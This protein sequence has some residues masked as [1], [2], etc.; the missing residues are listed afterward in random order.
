MKK[1]L[2]QIALKYQIRFQLLF[3]LILGMASF[4]N[5]QGTVSYLQSAE[6]RAMGS[7]QA[8]AYGISSLFGN[9]AGLAKLESFGAIATAE[10]RFAGSGI[11]FGGAGAAIPSELG[12]FGVKV[13]YF[14]IPAYNEQAIGI[15]YSRLLFESFSLSVQANL[16]NTSIEEYGSQFNI[17]GTLG[18]QTYLNKSITVGM[19]VQNPI[20]IEVAPDQFLPTIFSLGGQYKFPEK[21]TLRLAVEKDLE[22]AIGVQA[23]IA[24][25]PVE[26]LSLRVG[27]SSVANEL[28]FGAGFRISEYIRIDASAVYHQR[29]G[30]SPGFSFVYNKK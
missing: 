29:L 13:G 17:S 27:I 15:S 1:L 30:L 11:L 5:A 8:G 23:G 4:G 21:L 24:Y 18:F 9:P 7:S 6:S 12:V 14:G 19:Y 10:T 3:L 2:K 26:Q 28:S 22:A 20:Q 16:F 25:T